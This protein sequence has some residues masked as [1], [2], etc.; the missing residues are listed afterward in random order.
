M[1]DNR[2]HSEVEWSLSIVE[3]FVCV[4]GKDGKRDNK[5]AKQA[6][7][8]IRAANG[9]S[10]FLNL[11][12]HGHAYKIRSQAC[13]VLLG[14]VKD[15]DIKQIVEGK[16]ERMLPEI[17]RVFP[18]NNESEYPD[19]EEYKKLALRLIEEITGRDAKLIFRESTVDPAIRK[20][21]KDSIVQ[22]TEITYSSTELLKIIHDH[23]LSQ[24]LSKTAR[25][26][27]DEAVYSHSLFLFFS[28]KLF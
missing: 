9:I 28:F 3:N 17:Q 7:S 22:H 2:N 19:H 20:M 26:L 25:L 14:L 10:L 15:S 1:Y 23:L 13:R 16:L 6:R 5:L 18:P 11:L 4:S 12:K 24:G 8:S 21:E 27:I